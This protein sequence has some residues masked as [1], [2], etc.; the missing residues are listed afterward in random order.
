MKLR[1]KEKECFLGF[2]SHTTPDSTPRRPVRSLHFRMKRLFSSSMV[3]RSLSLPHSPPTLLCPQ[4]SQEAIYEPQHQKSNAKIFDQ[5]GGKEIGCVLLPLLFPCAD[6]T[7]A[8]ISDP[9]Q[10]FNMCMPDFRQGG[11]LPLIKKRYEGV[12]LFARFFPF[13]CFTS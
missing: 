6:L 4:I 5:R 10:W 3:K 11:L 12:P 7:P 1:M 8:G 13:T 2:G 9:S